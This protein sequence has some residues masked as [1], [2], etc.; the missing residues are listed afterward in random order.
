LEKIDAVLEA[1]PPGSWVWGVHL[2][3]S[4]GVLNDLTGL[5]RVAQRRRVR[6]CADC[7]S[8]LGAMALDLTGVYLASGTSGKSLGAY[9]GIA[10]V[11][12]ERRGL[13]PVDLA[14]MPGYL[15]LA[16]TL[17]TI[18]PRYTFAWPQLAALAAALGE[19]ETPESAAARYTNYAT[20]GAHVR[21]GLR[22]L[23]IAPL[24]EASIAAPVITTFAPPGDESSAAFVARA[25]SAG[26][27]VAGES[28][29]L[30][31]RR[32]VQAATMGAAS[33]ADVDAFIRF[34]ARGPRPVS[35]AAPAARS[36]A[37]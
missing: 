18:G 26:F 28:R 9:T 30:A 35:R 11:F 5:V 33:R 1:E 3:S 14:R 8:S 6:V 23:G 27:D 15:D 36:P 4:T 20:L 37:R 2:E 7:I 29:Y 31:R 25:A 17:D 22:E 32:L 16:A 12:A 34:L 24:A 19:Y 13:A 10:I 21:G